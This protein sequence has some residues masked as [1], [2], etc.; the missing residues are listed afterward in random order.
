MLYGYGSTREPLGGRLVGGVLLGCLMVA[1]L[2]LSILAFQRQGAT[3]EKAAAAA[4]A[5]AASPVTEVADLSTT[6]VPF[7]DGQIQFVVQSIR[8]LEATQAMQTETV[9]VVRVGVTNTGATPQL[10]SFADQLLLGD[11]GREL[12][13]DPALLPQLNNGKVAVLLPPD[14]DATMSI[15]YI[16]P[17]GTKPVA[18]TL[19]AGPEVPGVALPS[20]GYPLQS[21]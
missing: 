11:Q 5:A 3:T 7:L 14:G 17:I 20:N 16:V 15:P 18:I 4:A 9:Q 21:K 1:M 12:A 13:P 10:V 2:A 8:P 6:S 19:H